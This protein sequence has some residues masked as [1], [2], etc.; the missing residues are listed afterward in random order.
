[1]KHPDLRRLRRPAVPDDAPW[2]KSG[3][4][5]VTSGASSSAGLGGHRRTPASPPTSRNSRDS[6]TPARRGAGFGGRCCVREQAQ[7]DQSAAGKRERT[8]PHRG[9]TAAVHSR[10]PRSLAVSR[11]SRRPASGRDQPRPENRLIRFHTAEATRSGIGAGSVAQA[12]IGLAVP[13]RPIGPWSRRVGAPEASATRRD[14]K[15][16]RSVLGPQPTGEPR[17][18]AGRSG[19]RPLVRSAGRSVYSPLTSDGGECRRGVRASTQTASVDAGRLRSWRHGARRCRLR[20]QQPQTMQ[21]EWPEVPA[22]QVTSGCPLA[23]AD[24]AIHRSLLATGLPSASVAARSRPYST[25]TA[26]PSST[27]PKLSAWNASISAVRRADHFRDNARSSPRRCA[28]SSSLGSAPKSASAVA[29]V[30]SRSLSS[31]RAGRHGFC[32]CTPPGDMDGESIM[33]PT[34]QSSARQTQG[35]QLSRPRER[36]TAGR[37][38]HFAQGL[39]GI[40]FLA[41]WVG[42]SWLIFHLWRLPVAPGRPDRPSR[43][44][45]QGPDQKQTDERQVTL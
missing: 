41:G 23:V 10:Q 39:E 45:G 12:C 35:L 2:H 44:V 6:A 1:M 33:G 8:G 21:G 27:T 32:A 3:V 24:A 25:A 40:T 4:M 30:T 36:C 13:G 9:H 31:L 37:W 26:R 22:V 16:S 42:G 15:P 28:A 17:T 14:R 11:F 29:A 20:S 19:H 5:F 7:L 18:T 38:P 34:I 43:P